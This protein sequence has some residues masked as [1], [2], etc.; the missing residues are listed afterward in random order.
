MATAV[1]PSAVGGHRVP[2]D[3]EEVL[4]H[5]EMMLPEHTVH[6]SV[7]PAQR[8]GEGVQPRLNPGHDVSGHIFCLTLCMLFLVCTYD[9][10]T[11]NQG[12]V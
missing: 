2:H 10:Q 8:Q 5:M 4:L 9:G 1:A 3:P 11:L 6:C 12:S 7:D